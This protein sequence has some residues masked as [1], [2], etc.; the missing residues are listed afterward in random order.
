[1]AAESDRHFVAGAVGRLLW[2]GRHEHVDWFGS[3]TLYADLHI[4]EVVPR[5][6][7]IAPLDAPAIGQGAQE[8]DLLPTI[9]SD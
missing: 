6:E 1:M 2:H 3:L 7:L 4:E 9:S 5:A 8:G